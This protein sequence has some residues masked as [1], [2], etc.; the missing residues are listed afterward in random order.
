MIKRNNLIHLIFSLRRLA[1]LRQFYDQHVYTEPERPKSENS[2]PPR[3]W[4]PEGQRSVSKAS[5]SCFIGYCGEIFGVMSK[6]QCVNL[7]EFYSLFL[8]ISWYRVVSYRIHPSIFCLQLRLTKRREGKS[9]K[10]KKLERA[11]IH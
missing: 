8:I 9:C 1:T 4:P 2:R 10:C 5:F 7:E 11:Y 3:R 6:D